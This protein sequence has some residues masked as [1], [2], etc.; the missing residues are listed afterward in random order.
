MVVHPLLVWPRV[1]LP[2]FLS[3]ALQRAMV[4]LVPGGSLLL[5]GSQP[6]RWGHPCGVEAGLSSIGT[7]VCHVSLSLLGCFFVFPLSYISGHHMRHLCWSVPT[8]KRTTVVSAS[9]CCCR[10]VS[11]KSSLASHVFGCSWLSTVFFPF[12]C[13]GSM[14]AFITIASGLVFVLGALPTILPDGVRPSV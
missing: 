12:C 10:R 11:W 1:S 8:C 7:K 5:Y 9:P 3:F 6:S 2:S 4:G 14:S 13:Y